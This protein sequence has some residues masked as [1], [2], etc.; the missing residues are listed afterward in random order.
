MKNISKFV[1]VFAFLVSFFARASNQQAIEGIVTDESGQ[2]LPGV[3]VLVKGASRA[4]Q[5]DF[6]GKY[7]IKANGG[8]VL[9]F[10]YM[11]MDTQEIIVGSQKTIN[12]TLVE[13]SN[14]IDEVV[15]TALGIS[16]DRKKLGYAVQSVKSERLN[17]AGTTNINNALT[18]KVAGVQFMGVS[19]ADLESNP[20]IRV[21]GVNTLSGGNPLYVVDGTPIMNSSDVNMDDVAEISVLKGASASVLYGS[22]ALNGVIL[23]KTKSAKSGETKIT[24]TNNTTFSKLPRWYDTRFQ[25]QYGG[26]Y[27]QT[28]NTF[29]FDPGKHDADWAKF[30]GQKLVDYKADESWGPR[31]EGQM[32]RHWDSWYDGPEFGKLRAWEASP[33]PVSSLFDVGINNRLAVAVSKGTENLNTRLSYTNVNVKGVLPNSKSQ[34]NFLA[35]KSKLKISDSFEIEGSINYTRTL[36]EGDL[37]SKGYGNPTAGMFDQW[38]QRQIDLNRLKQYKQIH[39]GSTVYRTWN[40]KS[41]TN[42]TGLYWDSP[43]R[44][45]NENQRERDRNSLVGFI[46]LQWKINDKLTL[47]GVSRRTL[48]NY[49]LQDQNGATRRNRFV[50]SYFTAQYQRK[51]DNHEVLLTYKDTFLNELLS[52]DVI[53]GGISESTIIN[54]FQQTHGAVW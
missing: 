44:D 21:R 4:T 26:G 36:I 10:S 34:K 39:N 5:T 9:V 45:F 52:L 49:S 12:V 50:A 51:E 18:G 31:F 32:V 42:L 24:L 25:N 35:L 53:G 14:A 40:I 2:P 43:Y 46:S 3:T 15:V 22:R 8:E 29:K 23:I 20:N 16:R 27:K 47:K 11:G 28:F 1:L 48:R 13:S 37:R 54:S 30:N 19:G 7:L 33:T 6:D 41:P 38:Y 17:L